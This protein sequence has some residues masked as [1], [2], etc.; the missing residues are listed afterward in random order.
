MSE[1]NV[2]LIRGLYRRWERGDFATAEFFDPDIEFVRVGSGVAAAAGAWKGI[3]EMWKASVEW[4]EAWENMRLE[5]RRYVDLGD[6]VLAIVRQTSRGRRSGVELDQE[7]GQLFTIHQ[8]KV[9]RWVAYWE[10]SEALEAVGLADEGQI[11]PVRSICDGG[12][13]PA[14][15]AKVPHNLLKEPKRPT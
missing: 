9:V 14:G 8:G 13:G 7:N 3:D 15:G 2:E 10:A 11:L 6:R 12:S 4:L 5:P 1:E